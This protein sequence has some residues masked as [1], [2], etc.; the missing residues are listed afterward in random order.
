LQ[1]F[2]DVIAELST[3]VVETVSMGLLTAFA[4]D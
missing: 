3:L 2:F 4:T 1:T